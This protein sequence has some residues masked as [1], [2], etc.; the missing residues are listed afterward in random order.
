MVRVKIEG[1]AYSLYNIYTVV[2]TSYGIASLG[3]VW[4]TLASSSI[5]LGGGEKRA[6]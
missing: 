4:Y 1:T 3:S 5:S 6:W 2:T